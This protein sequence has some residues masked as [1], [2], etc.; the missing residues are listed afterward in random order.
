M[1]SNKKR[2]F[3]KNNKSKF[4]KGKLTVTPINKCELQGNVLDAR[5]TKTA[6][7]IMFSGKLLIENNRT[8]FLRAFDDMAK[9]LYKKKVKA[10]DPLHVLSQY[11]L[12][13]DQEGEFWPQF[14]ITELL[15]IAKSN[16]NNKKDKD[17]NWDDLDEFEDENEDEDSEIDDDDENNEEEDEDI[18]SM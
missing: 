8:I 3:S 1:K 15:E 9:K 16:K 2:E 18:W 10:G 17:I 7:G 6:N 11:R 12:Y 4:N 14:I 13:R 5:Y